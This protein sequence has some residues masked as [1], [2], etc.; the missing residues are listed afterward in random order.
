MPTSA[1]VRRILMLPASRL[2]K[3]HTAT[4]TIH[5][6]RIRLGISIRIT[7][8]CES[9]QRR[10]YVYAVKRGKVADVWVNTSGFEWLT[11]R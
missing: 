9:L 1:I 10:R 11:F 4:N 3:A 5:T 2:N 6:S 7:M 8:T